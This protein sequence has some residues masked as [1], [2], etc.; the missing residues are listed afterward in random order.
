MFLFLSLLVIVGWKKMN[1]KKKS[2]M[3]KVCVACYRADSL[4]ELF[5]HRCQTWGNIALHTRHYY[6]ALVLVKSQKL[7]FCAGFLADDFLKKTKCHCRL[8]WLHI[9]EDIKWLIETLSI[10]AWLN[11]LKRHWKY[12]WKLHLISFDVFFFFFIQGSVHFSV[13]LL[14]RCC[15]F[16]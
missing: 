10:N 5:T 13:T 16:K 12:I 4:L 11:I 15:L 8:E 9:N 2:Y 3:L 14:C 6:T 1:N 7:K